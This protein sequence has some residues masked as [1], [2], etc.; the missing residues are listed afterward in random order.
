MFS[1]SGQV[2]TGMADLSWKAERG[3]EDEERGVGLEVCVQGES[4][5]KQ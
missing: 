1:F 3:T 5:E 4:G 2:G